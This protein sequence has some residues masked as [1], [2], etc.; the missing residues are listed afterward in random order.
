MVGANTN[1]KISTTNRT[2]IG[3]IKVEL[4]PANERPNVSS[5]EFAASW[6]DAVGRIAGAEKL[7]FNAELGQRRQDL[8]F[9]ITGQNFSAVRAG[10]D[11]MVDYLRGIEAAYEVEQSLP[12]GKREIEFTLTQLVPHSAL[13]PRILRDKYARLSLVAKLNAFSAAAM[14]YA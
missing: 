2:H 7:S 13:P 5:K 3:E 14:N 10:A 4:T 6:R 9:D 12:A 1:G 8:Q 11:L